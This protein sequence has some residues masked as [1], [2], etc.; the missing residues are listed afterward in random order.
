MDGKKIDILMAQLAERYTA[1][2]KMRDRSMQF[3]LWILG[4]SLGLAWL[5]ISQITLNRTQMFVL[6]IFLFII[7]ILVLNFLRAINR[8]F[9][10]NRD[11][12]I[13]I[14]TLLKLH[15]EGSYW[16][17]EPVLPKE[18]SENKFRWSGHFPTLY[19]L[20]IAVFILLIILTFASPVKCN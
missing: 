13:K 5:L 19:L 15:E 14:E 1:L 7:G 10:N 4:L 16:S 11:V 17:T 12:M 2:H 3:A 6:G 8:G 18:F 20:I 9:N